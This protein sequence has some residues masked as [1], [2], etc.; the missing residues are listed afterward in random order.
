MLGSEFAFPGLKSW[1]V[2]LL[3]Q[4]SIY[5]QLICLLKT[6]N[7]GQLICLPRTKVLGS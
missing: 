1:A 3:S 4:D 5:G 2:D 7:V 6:P